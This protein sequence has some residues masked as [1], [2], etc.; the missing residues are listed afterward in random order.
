[1]ADLSLERQGTHFQRRRPKVRDMSLFQR[2]LKGM[3]LLRNSV[4]R[5]SEVPGASSIDKLCSLFTKPTS[6]HER[7]RQ[8]SQRHENELSVGEW[9]SSPDT[10]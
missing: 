7:R 10:L 1:M 3:A 6:K 9:V 8:R 5:F 4:G 2:P